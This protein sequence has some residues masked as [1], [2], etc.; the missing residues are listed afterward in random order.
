MEKDASLRSIAEKENPFTMKTTIKV[1]RHIAALGFFVFVATSALGAE[2][3]V[4][5]KPA[6]NPLAT[7]GSLD[8]PFPAIQ[9]AVNKSQPG[10]TIYIREGTYPH[11]DKNRAFVR[12][13]VS[14]TATAPIT[15]QNYGT[16][17]VLLMGRGF[18]DRDL[19]GDGKA[20]GPIGTTNESLLFIEAN[21]IHVRG[22][23]FSNSNRWGIYIKGDENQV[24]RCSI[25]DNWD[26]G[27]TID[28][29]TN[30]VSSVET[31]RNRHMSGII[32]RPSA[33]G[34]TANGNVI[35]YSFSHHNGYQPNGEKVLPALRDSA[36]GG[37]ADG[38]TVFKAC[39]DTAPTGE[40]WCNNNAVI[41]NVFWHNT[42]GSLDVSFANSLIKDNLSLDCCY[43]GV[44]QN[45]YKVLREVK[46]LVFVNNI[47]YH[48]RDTG[49]SFRVHQGT[50]LHNLAITS[51]DKGGFW[52]GFPADTVSFKNNL[53][54]FN[55]KSDMSGVSTCSGS[56]CSNNWAED[57]TG[58]KGLSGDPHLVG[59]DLPKDEAGN[60]SIQIPSG[61]SIPEKVAWFQKTVRETFSL[62][63]TSPALGTGTPV[64]YLDPW[65]QQQ[66]TIPFSGSAPNV[67][68]FEVTVP[69]LK[70]P[71]SLQ[72]QP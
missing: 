35:A 13:T 33:V 25:H 71:A 11:T 34:R 42:D 55:T 20:D 43:P 7:Q 52:L 9:D 10:D 58:S 69:I 66:V 26:A 41:G 70:A 16:E 3:F 48:D 8:N 51:L 39:S 67:G 12:I 46:N 36:G 40:N 5:V 1:L 65:S 24:E 63:S 50:F 64:S 38:F 44:G 47:S 45:G 22:L 53:S 60:I 4:D 72:V 37:N 62:S 27:V 30:L 49:F 56:Q 28:G 32:I 23:E 31:F 57:G 14:G 17:R 6:T 15:I 61:L 29:N 19:N 21:Y 18:E 59:N 2:Y 68:I 54:A